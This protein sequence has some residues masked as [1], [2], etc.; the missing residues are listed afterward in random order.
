VLA[1]EPHPG[2][3]ATTPNGP[4]A[5]SALDVL[6]TLVPS[7]RPARRL[8]PA[9]LAPPLAPEVAPEAAPAPTGHA[10]APPPSWLQRVILVLAAAVARPPGS[11][12]AP[13]SRSSPRRRSTRVL[14]GQGDNDVVMIMDADT[15]LD[16]GFLEVAAARMTND[17]A[18][19]AVG[20]LFCGQ[21]GAGLLGPLQRNEYIRYSREMR[22]RRGR[23]LVLTGTGSL[24]RPLALRTVAES[25]GTTLP[26][27]PG[28]VYD[29]AALTEDNEL[30]LALK[31]LGA[32]MTS[33][34]Q[35]TV[36]T[37][38]TD[39]TDVTPCWR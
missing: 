20:G 21:E 39:V 22:R 25:R 18:L 32:L 17:R 10:S 36:V 29:T 34:E 11:R 8:P 15:A 37:D 3:R 13:V 7:Q 5:S 26:G 23:V 9:E 16:D 1:D 2:A 4:R 30:T 35:C 33:P 6:D 31:S 28:D 38:V 19:L 12:S 14:P 24:F 27:T